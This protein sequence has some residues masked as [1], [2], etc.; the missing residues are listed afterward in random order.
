MMRGHCCCCVSTDK[1]YTLNCC[2]ILPVPRPCPPRLSFSVV[3]SLGLVSATHRAVMSQ[4]QRG[5]FTWRSISHRLDSA[6][7]TCL[8]IFYSLKSYFDKTC[9]QYT[10]LI[11]EWAG[12]SIFLGPILRV[13]VRNK[14]GCYFHSAQLHSKSY[15]FIF[16][17]LVYSNHINNISIVI[18]GLITRQLWYWH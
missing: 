14:G 5:G 17:N 15:N 9:L 13:L 8:N 6:W 3:V 4:Q 18:S 1:Q 11:P 12:I 16:E 10:D 7:F 2:F